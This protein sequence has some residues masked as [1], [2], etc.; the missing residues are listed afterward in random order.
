MQSYEC[1][2]DTTDPS[3]SIL[4]WHTTLQIPNLVEHGI[5]F[6]VTF[7]SLTFM[8]LD[9]KLLHEHYTQPP[10]SDN[11]NNVRWGAQLICG[12]RASYLVGPSFKDSSRDWLHWGFRGFPQFFQENSETV[13]EIGH[14]RFLTLSFNFLSHESP[15]HLI[16]Y[17]MVYE[18]NLFQ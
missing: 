8:F 4:Q 1:K 7:R 5:S 6:C 14:H 3:Q 12:C 18:S 11:S 10:L 16:Q 13:R 17:R 2:A 9:F 15:Q